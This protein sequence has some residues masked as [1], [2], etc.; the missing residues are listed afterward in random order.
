MRLINKKNWTV[1]TA[2][3]LEKHKNFRETQKFFIYRHNQFIKYILTL[4]R[5][6]KFKFDSNYG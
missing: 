4:L 1:V 3:S 5:H 6:I 2:C